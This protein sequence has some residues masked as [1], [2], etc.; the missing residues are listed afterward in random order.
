MTSA[1]S[2][3]TT[4]IESA[5]ALIT[6]SGSSGPWPS[7]SV[8]R[9]DAGGAVEGDDRRREE[10]GAD[11]DRDEEVAQDHPDPEDVVVHVAGELAER[12]AQRADR[13]DR[14]AEQGDEGDDCRRS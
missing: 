12:H 5:R 7:H 2:T 14:R 4:P 8:Q 3:N 6:V 10:G 11:A 9:A 13:A 1:S